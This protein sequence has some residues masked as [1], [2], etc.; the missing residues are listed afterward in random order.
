MPRVNIAPRHECRMRGFSWDSC[1]RCCARR[2]GKATLL[3]CD[4]RSLASWV[5]AEDKC[6][7]SRHQGER[8]E[9]GTFFFQAGHS[10]G[11]ER[12]AFPMNLEALFATI[13]LPTF[14][15]IMILCSRFWSG[16]VEVTFA[17]VM[18]AL[19]QLSNVTAGELQAIAKLVVWS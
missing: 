6:V 11:S 18:A 10:E 9:S 16:C 4:W 12:R 3:G 14:A 2:S 13:A 5:T 19:K 1:W 7:N 17:D 8:V 15:C